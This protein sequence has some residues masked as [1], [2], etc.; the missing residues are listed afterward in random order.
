MTSLLTSCDLD[1]DDRIAVPAEL[2]RDARQLPGMITMRAHSHSDCRFVM[3]LAR[4]GGRA[5]S[6]GAITTTPKAG[7]EVPEGLCPRVSLVPP[8]V[9]L[10]A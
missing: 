9:K 7:L 2:M 5:L 6:V 4:P 1:N 10:E 8:L 3:Q